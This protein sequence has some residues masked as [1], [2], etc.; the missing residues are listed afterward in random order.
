M[1]LGGA[2]LGLP[3]RTAGVRNGPRGHPDFLETAEARSSIY[4]QRL[5]RDKTRAFAGK[6]C[7][8]SRN[9]PGF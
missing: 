2:I 6:K 7:D 1:F 4:K 8:R 9:F 5:T 3:G